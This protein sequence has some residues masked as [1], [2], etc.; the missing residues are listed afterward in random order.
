MATQASRSR[1]PA[2]AS[3]TAFSWKFEPIDSEEGGDALVHGDSDVF[4]VERLAYSWKRRDR[5]VGYGEGHCNL[6]STVDF[7]VFPSENLL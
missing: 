7:F 5:K 3:L 2:M 1:Q 6:K 4:E